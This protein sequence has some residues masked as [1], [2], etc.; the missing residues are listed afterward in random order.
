MKKLEIY[1]PSLCCSTKV[2][3][4]VDRVAEDLQ[5]VAGQGVEVRRYTFAR[6][7]QAF[8][9][10]AEVIREMGAVMDRLPITVVDGK[11][12]AIGAH[13]SR[14]QFAQKL[15]LDLDSRDKPGAMTGSCCKQKSACC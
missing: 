2:D 12:V 3:P 4:V 6:E 7:P 13:L 9:A 8:A 5:W 10:N 14:A 11:I 1:D 15:D